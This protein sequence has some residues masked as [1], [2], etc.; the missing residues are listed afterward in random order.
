M[1]VALEPALLELRSA[2]GLLELVPGSVLVGRPDTE[3]VC[4]HDRG[5]RGA[6]GECISFRFAP[7]FIE[8]IANPS[9]AWEVGCL[10]PMAELVVL[11]ELA[12]S[13]ADG[14]SDVGLDE[15]GTLFVARLTEVVSGRS[16]RCSLG[17]GRDRQRAV[18]AA[19]WIDAQSQ[20]PIDL[21]ATARVVELGPFQFLRIFS[22][23]L[24]VTPHQYLVHC[25]LRHAARLLVDGTQAISDIAF[26][27][28]FGDVSNFVRAFHRA[29]GVSPRTFRQAARGP[30]LSRQARLTASLMSSFSK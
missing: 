5:A 14:T 2:L 17:S 20:E 8:G 15:V 22:R 23:V 26:E 16:H 12:Q 11:G 7:H 6:R 27:V 1:H 28:G 24:G 21:E 30:S 25:R 13:A 3:Y 10:P 19:L 9:K 29:A 18:D 4:S